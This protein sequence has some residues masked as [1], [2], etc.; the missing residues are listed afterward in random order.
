[1]LRIVF[2]ASACLLL[3]F[4]RLELAAQPAAEP[5]YLFSVG[6]A[7]SIYSE[8]LTEQRRFWVHLPD[9]RLAEGQR[10][11]VIY[12]L[13]AEMHLAALAAVQQYYNYFR[14]PEMI[15][16]GISNADN[17][18][19]DLTPTPIA[20]RNGAP[21]GDS[22]GADRFTSFL[23]DELIP[24]IDSRYPTTSHRV[25]IGHSYAGL[26]AIHTLATTPDLFTNYV[27]L[28]PSLDWDNQRWLTHTLE[29]LLSL[30]LSGKGLHVS[31]ANEII[32]FSDSLTVETVASDTTEYSLGIRSALTFVHQL[33]SD[34]PEGL[35]FGW[36]FSESD[37]HGSIPLLGMRHGLTFL[38]DF[39]EL[40]KPS[41][42]NDPETP[43]ETLL[44]MI[45]SQ[46][47]ARSA[48]MGYPLPM[49]QE[50]LEMLALM[51]SDYGQPEKARAI[52]Q[53]AVE[54]YPG[55]AELHGSLMEICLTLADHA[56]AEA[57]ARAADEINGGTKHIELVDKARAGQ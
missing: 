22:G 1:M 20:S 43:T 12:L 5:A 14:M 49:E 4:P 8:T 21:I 17:R 24:L 18:T 54:Y 53:L 57:H 38:Y 35:R 7:D 32:R 48:N 44:S 42:Y 34:G 15:V 36:E 37:I 28:D 41:L 6:V 30:D 13:D 25:L 50:L 23:A 56:C 3:P 46:S 51:S 10:Y 31:I 29:S 39:W 26:F 52:L 16:V 27:A 9:G 2:L 40:K 47:D 11:P 19:R 55:E 45:R 33:E